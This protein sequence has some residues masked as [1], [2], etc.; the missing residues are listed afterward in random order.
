MTMHP[1]G[2]RTGNLFISEFAAFF[3]AIQEVAVARNPSLLDRTRVQHKHRDCAIAQ[4]SG[5][6][7]DLHA[8]PRR[9]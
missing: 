9:D 6:L 8:I 1:G 3:A 4:R 5:G 2:E 7:L